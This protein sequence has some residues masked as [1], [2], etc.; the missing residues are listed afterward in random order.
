MTV[1]EPGKWRTAKGGQ[2]QDSRCV[3]EVVRTSPPGWLLRVCGVGGECRDATESH[4]DH[5]GY[6]TVTLPLPS[7]LVL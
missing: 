7:M 5:R 2:V 3:L 1:A 4:Q 6:Q